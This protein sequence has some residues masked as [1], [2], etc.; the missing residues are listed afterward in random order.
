[1]SVDVLG[2]LE[3]IAFSARATDVR[4]GLMALRRSVVDA[5][6]ASELGAQLYA[7]GLFEVAADIVIRRPRADD[8]TVLRVL[9]KFASSKL[10]RDAYDYHEE[11]DSDG[12]ILLVPV[13]AKSEGALVALAFL[14]VIPTIARP[15]WRRYK[16][17]RC[18][19]CGVMFKD[20]RPKLR[21]PARTVCSPTC[22]KKDR[23]TFRIKRQLRTCLMCGSE[24]KHKL[25][26]IRICTR[27][28]EKKR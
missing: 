17:L 25:P 1:V 19:V 11:R 16:T 8:E 27:C 12:S 10:R 26:Y 20:L 13:K 28:K 5:P 3:L 23:H 14:R 15:A 7:R 24:F 22:R 6:L 4:A 2:A 21:G 18:R 9:S